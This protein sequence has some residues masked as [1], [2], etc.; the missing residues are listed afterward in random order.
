[1]DIVE[2]MRGFEANHALVPSNRDD[3][4][5]FDLANCRLQLFMARL[6]PRQNKYVFGT[7]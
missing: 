1:M 3:M 7:H 6:Q 2:E 4:T 5:H